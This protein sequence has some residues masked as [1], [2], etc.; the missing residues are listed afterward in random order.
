MSGRTKE[1]VL[2]SVWRCVRINKIADAVSKNQQLCRE[3]FSFAPGWHVASYLAL[4]MGD[5]S[6]PL[7]HIEKSISL[8]PNNPIWRLHHLR[9]LLNDGKLSEALVLS[10]KLLDAKLE[11]SSQYDTLGRLLSLRC[12]FSLS[13]S[14]L[15]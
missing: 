3:H 9:C 6:S 13:S 11:L 15:S 7:T 14:F 5:A 8:E 2:E 4:H 10:G 1:L 12:L